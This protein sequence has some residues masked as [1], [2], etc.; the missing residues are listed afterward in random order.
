MTKSDTLAAGHAHDPEPFVLKQTFGSPTG[1]KRTGKAYVNIPDYVSPE[2]KAFLA[3]LRDPLE[4]TP[5]FPKD[6]NNPAAWKPLR[7]AIGART[8]VGHC[9]PVRVCTPSHICFVPLAGAY[10]YATI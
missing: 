10:I 5:P 6:W 8:A 1:P 4:T 3:E 2:M 9:V 7:D